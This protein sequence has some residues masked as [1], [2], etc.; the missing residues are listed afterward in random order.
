MATNKIDALAH[1]PENDPRNASDSGS[2]NS[3]RILSAKAKDFFSSLKNI[4]KSDGKNLL[5]FFQLFAPF[6][7][8]RHAT[9]FFHQSCRFFF[10]KELHTRSLAN[11]YIRYCLGMT[12]LVLFIKPQQP[13]NYAGAR[14]FFFFFVI[15][16]DKPHAE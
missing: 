15:K 3:N 5:L 12:I 16:V 14:L 8:F 4:F 6:L 13:M 7:F 11:F 1:C 10:I 2:A 9:T